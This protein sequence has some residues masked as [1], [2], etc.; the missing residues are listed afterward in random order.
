MVPHR[1]DVPGPAARAA[2]AHGP[3]PGLDVG[4]D[5]R[6]QAL[7]LA[8]QPAFEGRAPVVLEHA[9]LLEHFSSPTGAE[10]E[11]LLHLD[12]LGVPDGVAG[13]VAGQ[14]DDQRP[15][16]REPPSPLP[17]A[18]LAAPLGQVERPGQPRVA[19]ISARV[20]VEP[21]EVPASFE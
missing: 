1:C 6:G 15:A 21:G 14:Q 9:H 11:G 4:A 7:E 20:L 5:A 19:E 2:V 8:V 17:A 12:D 10:V 3:Q 13:F 16:D 18:G